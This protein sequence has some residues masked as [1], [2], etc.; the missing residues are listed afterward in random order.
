MCHHHF[1]SRS[2]SLYSALVKLNVLPHVAQV[3]IVTKNFWLWSRKSGSFLHIKCNTAD[4]TKYNLFML[5]LGVDQS[6]NEVQVTPPRPLEI[7][8]G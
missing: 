2:L 5:L 4:V 6:C 3:D 8:V 1:P 7:G